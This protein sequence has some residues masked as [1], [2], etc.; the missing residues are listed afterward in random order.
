MSN[1]AGMKWLRRI[2][3]Q[4]STDSLRFYLCYVFIPMLL[5]GMIGAAITYVV[6]KYI[7]RA[8]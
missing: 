5:G 1:F 6:I 8:Q 3:N 7:V 4:L 2:K